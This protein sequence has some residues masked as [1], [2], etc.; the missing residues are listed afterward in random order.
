MAERLPED[1]VAMLRHTLLQLLLEVPAT[2]LVLAQLRDLA[3][4][5]FQTRTRKSVDYVR[6]RSTRNQH[7]SDGG[8]LTLAVDI[9]TL[10]LG[11]VQTV[12]LAVNAVR[13]A[14]HA[15]TVLRAVVVVQGCRTRSANSCSTTV[16]FETIGVETSI[17]HAAAQT[18]H[19]LTAILLQ[20]CI[21][22]SDTTTPSSNE[23]HVVE[24]ALHRVEAERAAVEL[25]GRHARERGVQITVLTQLA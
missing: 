7:P 13:A 15:E 19:A 14:V 20:Q 4:E 23:T 24:T 16:D 10:V 3:G 11:A 1:H 22:T 12:H 18:I 9:P 5:V 17:V 6:Q 21:N 8:S 2:V 25:T